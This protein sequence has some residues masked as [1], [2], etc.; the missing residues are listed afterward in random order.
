MMPLQA[1]IQTVSPL[2]DGSG[3]VVTTARYQTPK[4]TDINKKGIEVD[5][6]KDCP[7]AVEPAKCLPSRI[8]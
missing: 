2:S 5:V 8:V 3:I 1:V 6:Q 7:V 4:R